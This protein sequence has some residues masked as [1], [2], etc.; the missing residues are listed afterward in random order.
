M[1]IQ[2]IRTQLSHILRSKSS[3][4]VSFVLLVAVAINF[5]EN[6]NRN[7]EALYVT[8]MYDLVKALT[9]SDWT[10]VGYFF[11]Q[12]YPLLVV[13]PTAGVYISDKKSGVD[14]YIKSRVG[15]KNYLFGKMI[16]V[17]LA[18]LIIFFIPFF[19]ELILSIICFDIRSLGDPSGFE[20]WQTIERDGDY[21]LSNIYLSNRILYATIM[22]GLFGLVSAILATF[23]FAVTTLPIFKFRLTTYFPI[24]ILFY[25]IGIVENIVKPKFTMYYAFILRMFEVTKEKNYFIYAIFLLGLLGISAL[26]I[27]LKIRHK[28]RDSSK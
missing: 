14:T 24:Y 21:F 3:V 28:V 13:V 23:N 11:M 5:I 22:T 15:D 7:Y 17:F 9:L 12:Y 6:M 18:T 4:F 26:L 27:W 16:S 25:I 19:V 1:L 2:S 10:R 20:Y 8:E